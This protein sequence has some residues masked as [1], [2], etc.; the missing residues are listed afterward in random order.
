M[1][2]C[3]F[4]KEHGSLFSRLHCGLWLLLNGKWILIYKRPLSLYVVLKRQAGF[5]CLSAFN[6]VKESDLDSDLPLPS[7]STFWGLSSFG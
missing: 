3:S 1:K 5:R 2:D 6:F 7:S 4:F